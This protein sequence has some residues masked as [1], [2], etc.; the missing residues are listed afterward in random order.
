MEW[1][2]TPDGGCQVAA[3]L[4]VHLHSSLRSQA[5]GPARVGAGGSPHHA[6]S[7]K[8]TRSSL[9]IFDPFAVF[10]IVVWLGIIGVRLYRAAHPVSA[11]S[12]HAANC[13][14]LIPASVAGCVYSLVG[15][16]DRLSM[17]WLDRTIYFFFPFVFLAIIAC[18]LYAGM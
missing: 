6:M 16:R 17:S 15:H 3:P 18:V 9:R 13:V 1:K 14:V 2:F 11:F 7:I 10:G 8:L 5:S 12:S 4:A